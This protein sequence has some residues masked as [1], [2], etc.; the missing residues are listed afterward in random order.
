M[1]RAAAVRTDFTA[2]EVRQFVKW[3]RGAAQAR[4][5]S[6][7]AEVFTRILSLRTRDASPDRSERR[8]NHSLFV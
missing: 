7:R 6:G 1:G 2:G 8:E 5:D 3:T 4:R